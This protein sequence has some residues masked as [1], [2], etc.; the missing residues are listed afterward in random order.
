MKKV[1]FVALILVLASCNNDKVAPKKENVEVKPEVIVP[2]KPEIFVIELKLKYSESEDIKLFATDV[3]INNN[4]T[5][6]INVTEKVAKS[7]DFKPVLLDFPENIKP[8]YQVGISFGTKKPKT[9]EVKSIY[10]SYADTEFNIPSQELNNYFTFNKFVDY[11]AETG[12]I[13]TKKIAGKHN[14]LMFFRRKILDKL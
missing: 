12:Q 5:M 14:P 8:D 7:D 13:Q 6:N 1:F 9:I 3:F 4:R 11:N 10:I 2:I